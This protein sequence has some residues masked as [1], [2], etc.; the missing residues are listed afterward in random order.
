YTYSNLL[1]SSAQIASHILQGKN[2]LQEA[3]VAFMVK[4]G[5]EYVSTLWGIW[6]AGGIAVPLCLDHPLPSLQY[7]LEDTGANVVIVSEDL[8]SILKDWC[9]E[10][11]I[12]L[13]IVEKIVDGPSATSFP[14]IE[15]QRRAMILYTSG[16]T[17]LPKGVVSTHENLEAQISTLV[18]AWQWKADDQ[19][20]CVLP[21]H[22]VHGIVNVVC[23]S[24]WAGACC[25]FLSHSFSPHDV[26]SVFLQERINV[27]MAV[28]TIYF[29]LIAYWEGLDIEQRQLIS[30]S[31]KKF[32][33]MVSGSAALP[34]SVMEKW[35]AISGH[36]L[37]ERYGMTEMGMAISN[38]YEGERRPGHVG[39]PL[40]GVQIR[41]Y[42]EGKPVVNGPGE[43]QVK[44]KN[45]FHEYWQKPEATA[46]SFTPD[47]WFKTGDIAEL[48]QGYYKILGRDSVD[49]IKSGG[50][51]ISA[52]E[53]EE[54]LRQHGSIKDCSV[55][56]IENEEWGELVAACYVSDV[57]LEASLLTQW[58]TERIPRYKVPRLYMHVAEL[59]RNAMGKVVKNELKN[60]F[61]KI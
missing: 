32:R 11:N 10:R 39:K 55:V 30:A 28:P 19:I 1:S 53:I 15:A 57:P 13:I 36:T 61:K 48:N 51:K 56:G 9:E 29:K 7:V 45:V 22:H 38:P 14:V 34:V 23:C 40:P 16:T 47:G 52:L 58:L 59:P 24:L 54:A 6:C 2:D 20:L 49:I 46:N 37:L 43:I 12:Q 4:P 27:F 25:E 5:F 31:L 50:Y 33:L 44:G 8:Q 35:K 21:L 17:N 42:D 3:R 26:F 41:L 60:Y 18:D